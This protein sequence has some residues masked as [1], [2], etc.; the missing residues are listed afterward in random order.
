MGKNIDLCEL[1]GAPEE[2][3][4]S[5]CGAEYDPGFWDYDI[6]GS[7]IRVGDEC[8]LR[9]CCGE[10]GTDQVSVIKCTLVKEVK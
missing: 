5:N 9:H 10:C 8:R 1:I 4:C 2:V 7:P 6:D 3:T